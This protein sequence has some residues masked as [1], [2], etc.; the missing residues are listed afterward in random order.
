MARFRF[1]GLTAEGV[2]LDGEISA[3]GERAA[4]VEL[5]RRGLTVVELAAADA[6][7]AAVLK[8]RRPPSRQDVV[9]ALRGLSTLLGA[10]VG[11]AEAVEAQARALPH[12][13]LQD[14]FDGMSKALRQGAAFSEALAGTGL[15]L[16]DYVGVVVRSGERA[17]LLSGAIGD[18]AAQMAYDE[19]VRAEVKQALIYPMVLIAAGLVAVVIMFAFVV[20]KFSAL[21]ERGTDLPWLAWAVLASG[22]FIRAQWAWLLVGSVLLGLGVQRVLANPRRR[23]GLVDAL[24]RLPVLGR[25]RVESETASWA[26]VFATLLANRVPMME[27]LELAQAAVASRRR[28]ARLH[29]VRRAV[30][31]GAPLAEALEQQAVLPPAG[32]SLVRVGVRSGELPAMLRSLAGMCDSA[33]KARLK[34]FLAL[35]EPIAILVIGGVVGIIMIGIILAITSANDLVL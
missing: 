33:G 14:A 27:A 31:A 29:E 10:G 35:L 25:W 16:P 9:L 8:P 18:A 22:G 4:I 2:S 12:P 23:D 30:K 13:T 34:Q 11:L 19:E 24:E 3:P 21:L 20:P 7:S 28:R 15:P 1:V 5:E 26:R 17:G 32:G 6:P